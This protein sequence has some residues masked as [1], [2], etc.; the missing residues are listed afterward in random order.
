MTMKHRVNDIANILKVSQTT[1]YKKVRKHKKS[2]KPHCEKISGI[3]M[4]SDEGLEIIRENISTA[5]M[6]TVTIEKQENILPVVSGLDEVKRAVVELA[7]TFKQSMNNMQREMESI[8]RENQALHARLA[9]LPEPNRKFLPWKPEPPAPDPLAKKSLL[10]RFWIELT[11][12]E[13][14]RRHPN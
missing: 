13:Q 3:L 9:P 10:Q 7:V 14:M 4:F 5:A 6:D 11:K 8:R 1:V 2:L 12:P